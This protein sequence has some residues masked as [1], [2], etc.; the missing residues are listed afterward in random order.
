MLMTLLTLAA[1]IALLGAGGNFLVDGSAS[2]AR[3]AGV[4]PLFI[5]LTLMGLGTSAPEL[6]TSLTAASRGSEGI[7]LG[8][9]IGSNI[10]NVLLVGGAT[11]LLFGALGVTRAQLLRDGGFGV[12]VAALLLVALN[13]TGLVPVW[14][15]AFLTLICLYLY[16]CLK[17][18]RVAPVAVSAP[19]EGNEA[20]GASADG[21]PGA[22]LSGLLALGGLIAILV[23]ARF[24]VDAAVD[25]ARAFN[26]SEA[27]VGLTIVAVGTSLPEIAA[28]FIA[29]IRGMAAMAVGNILGSNIFNILLIGGTIAF[30]ANG[31]TPPDIARIDAPTALGAAILLVVV[32]MPKSR[33]GSVAGGVMVAAY[34]LY[35]ASLAWR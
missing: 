1:G 27:S 8:N 18:E 35:L 13:T 7:A 5:G 24:T 4:S 16:V 10:A 17:Q 2:V 25:I 11:A 34:A 32:A 9:I 15:V 14:G 23:G 19:G 26:L 3:R 20:Q 30:A 31:E 28:S 29:A 6:A 22:A 33:I 21:G 12:F